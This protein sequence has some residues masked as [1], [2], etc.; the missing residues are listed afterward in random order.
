M[1]PIPLYFIA[2]LDL[3]E[4]LPPSSYTNSHPRNQ[5][6]YSP[7]DSFIEPIV[8]QSRKPRLRAL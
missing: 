2:N 7:A 5:V 8:L 4:I 3:D 1:F 6:P